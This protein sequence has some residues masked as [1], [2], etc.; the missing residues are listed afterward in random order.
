MT[1]PVAPPRR[2]R[3]AVLTVLRTES[4]TPQMIRVVAGG[5]GLANFADNDKT[6][7]YVKVGFKAPGVEY[8][9]P[10]DAAEIRATM[11]RSV[12][13]V[14]RTYTIRSFDPVAGELA[15]DF[16]VHGDKGLAG[17]WAERAQPGD[18]LILQGSGGAYSPDPA[19][20]WHLLVA[21][22]SA[23]PAVLNAAEA[24]PGD[25]KVQIFVEVA[26]ASEEQNFPLFPNGQVTYLHSGSVV[27]GDLLIQ[28]VSQTQWW[29]GRVQAF[30]HGEAGFVRELRRHLLGERGI[31]RAD[32]SISGYWR[33]GKTEDGF[34][35]EKA[36][37]A[38]L[39]P[40][41]A[42]G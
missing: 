17:P 33:V 23:L 4:V 28:A 6:D 9:E 32:L 8:P 20:D 35:G 21:D 13:P 7:H 2:G 30:V 34:R 27:P 41:P 22:S 29:P 42:Q 18:E 31:D 26:N 3:A 11:D 14:N 1:T 16:V 12:W 36:A 10:F 24:L 37:G 19:A 38:A 15:I 40:A 5:P 39:E 25:A